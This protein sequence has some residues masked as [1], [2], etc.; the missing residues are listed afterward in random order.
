M[1]LIY[2]GRAYTPNLPS[3]ETQSGI[4]EATY[5]GAHYQVKQYKVARRAQPKPPVQLTY[6]GSTYM[7]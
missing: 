7:R 4:A 5:R 1:E 2:R 3:V 6:R